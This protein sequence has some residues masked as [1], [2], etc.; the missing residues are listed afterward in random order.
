MGGVGMSLRYRP[1]PSFAFDFGVDA[2]GGVDFNGDERSEVPIS[3]SGMI[4]LNPR[5]RVQFYLMGGVHVS[6]AQVEKTM[7]LPAEDPSEPELTSMMMREYDYFG[8]QGGIGLE[9]RLS[10]RVALNIDALAFIRDGELRLLARQGDPVPGLAG[11]NFGQLAFGRPAINAKGQVMHFVPLQGPGVTV[12]SDNSVFVFEPDGTATLVA[13]EGDSFEVAPGDARTI[14]DFTLDFVWIGG[15]PESGKRTAF[16]NEGQVGFA[17]P[18]TDESIAMVLADVDG[19]GGAGSGGAGGSGG[20][21]GSGDAGGRHLHGNRD[22][23]Y[24]LHR[25]GQRDRWRRQRG[26]VLRS[27]ESH[28][29]Q[30]HGNV[31]TPYVERRAG[32]N[33]VHRAL[34]SYCGHEHVADAWR[35][36]EHGHAPR[37]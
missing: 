17:L 8:G 36:Y 16:N 4:F 7:L 21:G 11:V 23:R 34:R 28:G 5:S 2:V 9:F 18:F 13:R 37:A 20:V 1:V 14:A 35:G 24:G 26:H 19:P 12:D 3:L 10:R 33:S 30:H 6:H 32:R 25:N 31:R 29:E 15:G 27:V 22:D